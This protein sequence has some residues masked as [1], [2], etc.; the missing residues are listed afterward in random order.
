[1]NLVDCLVFEVGLLV[2]YCGF[3]VYI[4]FYLIE[5]GYKEDILF[6]IIVFYCKY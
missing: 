4:Y 5:I 2:I 3:M 6:F 1:M